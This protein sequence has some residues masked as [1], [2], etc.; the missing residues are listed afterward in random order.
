MTPP[1]LCVDWW[2]RSSVQTFGA[3]S[4]LDLKMLQFSENEHKIV[5][6]CRFTWTSAAPTTKVQCLPP[7]CPCLML[8]KTELI[9]RVWTL[10]CHPFVNGHPEA[11]ASGITSDAVLDFQSQ[12]WFGW[13]DGAG[14][15][16]WLDLR[17]NMRTLA[18]CPSH[19]TS[20]ALN[21]ALF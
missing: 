17:E 8:N 16:I 2:R 13:E 12:K 7:L 14:G 19:S 10:W 3:D 11:W 9:I 15:N 18:A 21:S 20:R 1:T 5:Q 6:N 4:T